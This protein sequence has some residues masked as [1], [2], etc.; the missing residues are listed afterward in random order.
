MPTGPEHHAMEDAGPR[1]VALA[2]SACTSRWRSVARPAISDSRASSRWR[3][4]SSHVASFKSMASVP[5]TSTAIRLDGLKKRTT[6]YCSPWS[7]RFPVL[8]YLKLLLPP[9]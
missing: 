3:S 7:T 9:G 6:D 2:V 5:I 8:P 1:Y 4:S